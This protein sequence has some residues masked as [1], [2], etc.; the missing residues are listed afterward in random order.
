MS[1][2]EH[3]PLPLGSI[4]LLR[5]K[6]EE[7]ER[8]PI[9]CDL[10][11]CPAVL[12]SGRSSLY[13]ALSYVWGSGYKPRSILI[14]SNPRGF[15]VGENLYAALV[16]LR[17]PVFERLVWIDA[18]C[19]NQDDDTEK[20]H[21]VQ[22]MARIYAKARG[23]VVW[24]GPE[25]AESARAFQ[26]I[27]AFALQITKPRSQNSAWLIQQLACGDDIMDLIGRPWF[28]RI[29]VLQEVA[30]ARHILIKAGSD[31]MSGDLFCAG[32]ARL[33]EELDTGNHQS[34]DPR[35]KL[36]DRLSRVSPVT[37][38]MENAGLRPRDEHNPSPR[39]S[40]NIAPLAD[41][42]EAYR[43]HEATDR[44]DKIYA[45][46]GMSSD[47]P[48]AAGMVPD[49]AISFQE[50]IRRY[51]NIVFSCK[52]AV[53]ISDDGNTVVIKATGFVLQVLE[54]SST[55][56]GSPQ[57]PGQTIDV[58]C[59]LDGASK[60]TVIRRHGDYSKVVQ[61][62]MHRNDEM[63]ARTDELLFATEFLLVDID[64]PESILTELD[65]PL[66]GEI[67][68]LNE[69][70]TT[71]ILWEQLPTPQQQSA[72]QVLKAVVETY[73]RF[74]TSAQS[75][76]GTEYGLQTFPPLPNR[77]I[78]FQE[79]PHAG[80]DYEVAEL[81]AKLTTISRTYRIKK[82]GAP[83]ARQA[84]KIEMI[85]PL[86]L[87]ASNGLVLVARS[88][89]SC[90]DPVPTG[91]SELRLAVNRDNQPAIR[92]LLATGKV[93]PWVRDVAGR[94]SIAEDVLLG[95]LHTHRNIQDLDLG[96]SSQGRALHTFL[97]FGNGIGQGVLGVGVLS[98]GYPMDLA[99]LCFLLATYQLDLHFRHPQGRTIFMMAAIGDN[100]DVLKYVLSTAEA[101]RH[102]CHDRDSYGQTPLMLAALH[103]SEEAVRLIL[104]SGEALPNT[105]DNDGQTALMLAAL[106]SHDSITKILM[107]LE[108]A[109]LDFRTKDGQTLLML[110]SRIGSLDSIDIGKALLKPDVGLA[111]LNATDHTGQTALLCALKEGK[112]QYSGKNAA[113]GWKFPARSCLYFRTAIIL[114][115]NYQIDL[116]AVDDD[117]NSAISLLREWGLDVK[118]TWGW[119]HI[120]EHA[121]VWYEKKY[122]ALNGVR[123][124]TY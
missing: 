83:N 60:P 93:L 80:T 52:A 77:E 90:D 35:N 99:R 87:A 42:I 114:L 116:G 79:Q 115:E 26:L 72:V 111:Q 29:W 25:T 13:E 62:A 50:L 20:G 84:S 4:R 88:I 104:A 27:Q 81:L 45:L 34:F 18:V 76:T 112:R 97:A 14:T 57:S 11:E 54:H 74:L 69:I 5:I 64:I 118:E 8:A 38:L 68:L 113:Q 40:V 122:S 56:Y 7:D 36:R 17:D 12:N 78:W 6:P 47:D 119:G 71:Y 105:K 117:G 124:R 70:M 82:L 2:Y 95:L 103:C 98:K 3:R 63:L 102:P 49:Y 31:E 55:Y 108:Q 33:R 101:S 61:I 21:Q 19:I 37:R 109:E 9:E 89:L 43:G 121:K 15:P 41:L 53:H 30:A 107:D 73:H 1:A 100:C 48:G 39:Y 66:K 51:V 65:R 46:L 85:S 67:R 28:K 32:L 44:R 120:L 10:L 59:Q 22:T 75:Q 110:A 123:V 16:S 86:F 58:V 24:L 94:L 92:S 91:E 106:A 23:V 96:M